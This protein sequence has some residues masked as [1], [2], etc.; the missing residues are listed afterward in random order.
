MNIRSTPLKR[1]F[2]SG[3][4]GARTDFAI[5]IALIVFVAF[6]AIVGVSGSPTLM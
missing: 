2:R 6:A 3:R 4:C 1:L 5:I